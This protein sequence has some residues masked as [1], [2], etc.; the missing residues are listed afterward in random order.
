[1][2]ALLKNHLEKRANWTKN[3]DYLWVACIFLYFFAMLQIEISQN[4]HTQDHN[5]ANAFHFV[6]PSLNYHSNKILPHRKRKYCAIGRYTFTAAI[7]MSRRN[8]MMSSYFYLLPVY[9]CDRIRRDKHLPCH[10]IDHELFSV[11]R[12]FIL[13]R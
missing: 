6:Y 8:V 9:F 7:N 4:E 2:K 10:I 12:Y 5:T 3:G 11:S 1:M 13:F